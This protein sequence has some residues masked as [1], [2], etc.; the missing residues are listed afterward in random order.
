[1]NTKVPFL[2]TSLLYICAFLLFLEWLYPVREIGDVTNLTVFILY[3][4]FCFL[5][6]MLHVT[7]W[8]SIPL[9][10]IG[11]LVILDALYLP[12]PFLGSQW[13]TALA[14]QISFNVNVLFSGQ[15]HE[16]TPMFRSVLFLIMIWMLSYLLYY[17]FIVM[18]RIFIFIML[19]FVYLSVLDTFTAYNANM[20]IVRTFIVSFAALGM[21]HL[22]KVV[23][24]ESIRFAWL[25]KALFWTVP[26]V[27]VI[28]L[29]TLIGYAAPKFSP[30]WPD[31]VPFIQNVAENGPGSGSTVRKIGYGSDD[32]RLGGGFVQDDTPIFHATAMNDHYW[33][34]ETKDIYT[35][36]GWKKSDNASFE[37]QPNGNISLDTFQDSVK[38]EQRMTTVDFQ[39]QEAMQKLVYPY[40]IDNVETAQPTKWLLDNTFD[41]IRPERN[42]KAVG[43]SQYTVTYEAP[44]FSVDKL[45]DVSDNDSGLTERVQAR[46]TQLPS[47]LPD[48]VGELAAEITAQDDNRYDKAKSLETYFGRNGFTYQIQNVPVPD[49]DQDYV[50]QFLFHSKEGYC[51]NYSTSMTVM[52]RS[53]D[54]PARWVKGFTSGKIIQSGD[55]P[56]DDDVYEVTNAN[57][58]SWV[59]VYFPGSGWVPFEPTQGFSNLADFHN[60]DGATEDDELNAPDNEDQEQQPEEE[61]E[62]ETSQNA[63]SA[64]GWIRN[65]W[66]ILAG[67]LLIAVAAWLAYR[68]RFRWMTAY[69]F[70]KLQRK[71][72]AKAFQDA[73]HYLLKALAHYGMPKYPGQTLREFA[74]QVDKHYNMEA[75]KPLTLYYERVLY[76]NELY[77]RETNDWLQWWKQLMDQILS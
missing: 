12:G 38:T 58:H 40:G 56:N 17:W 45:R 24:Q 26:L 49:E 74:E 65:G 35:G 76:N 71:N 33:R 36:K 42:G 8:L 3:T 32:T 48:R 37:P 22:Y 63:E 4:L 55:K 18:K 11:M 67:I 28:A 25:K 30:Q 23:D 31:P 73:Y 60:D 14:T 64:T 43:L 19:T 51:D 21:S 7:W 47:S 66:Y 59:E 72:D 16:L 46:Y 53:L 70:R 20:A 10:G 52:L 34:V 29:S 15:W 5:L 57:A 9:K 1:M 61:T 75:M 27:A 2:F 44:S 39:K 54:I 68:W 62:P 6:S 50:D 13:M 77:M 41:E 69:V